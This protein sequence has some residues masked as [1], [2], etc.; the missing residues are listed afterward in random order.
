MTP[1]SIP[2]N[3]FIQPYPDPFSQTM[4]SC[5]NPRAMAG[6]SNQ[7]IGTKNRNWTVY[8]HDKNKNIARGFEEKTT[9]KE[10]MRNGCDSDSDQ[11]RLG[12]RNARVCRMKTVVMKMSGIEILFFKE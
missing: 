4:N 7:D 5:R 8:V 10:A 9:T 3:V 12:D 2:A 6:V 1:P 11:I